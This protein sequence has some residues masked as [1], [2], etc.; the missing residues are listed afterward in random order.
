MKIISIHSYQNVCKCFLYPKNVLFLKVVYPNFDILLMQFI[1]TFIKLN[2]IS[3]PSAFAMNNIGKGIKLAF[4]SFS[5]EVSNTQKRKLI[6]F[7]LFSFQ[8]NSKTTSERESQ[9]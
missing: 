6:D 4:P 5:I 1:S 2:R 8:K 7:S 3:L 9:L